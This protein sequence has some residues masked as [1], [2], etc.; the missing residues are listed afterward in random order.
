MPISLVF[1]IL[2]ATLVFSLYPTQ[3]AIS[4]ARGKAPPEIGLKFAP[5]RCWIACFPGERGRRCLARGTRRMMGNV[6]WQYGKF[7]SGD[8]YICLK[9]KEK[10]TKLEWDIHFWIGEESSTDEMGQ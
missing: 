4:D 5:A 3:F 2:C 6:A 7:Y 9:T 10:S 8:S 1:R